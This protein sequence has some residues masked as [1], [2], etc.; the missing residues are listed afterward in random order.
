MNKKP[1]MAIA[2]LGVGA[3]VFSATGRVAAAPNPPQQDRQ[4]CDR[5]GR[6]AEDREA[7]RAQWIQSG[8]NTFNERAGA[9]G[10][11]ARRKTSRVWQRH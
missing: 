5:V 8:S 7:I 6:Y 10:K 3:V 11:R 2:A 1:Y 4:D 9:S